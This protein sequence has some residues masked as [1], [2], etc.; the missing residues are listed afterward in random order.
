LA[1]QIQVPRINNNLPEFD[2]AENHIR[3]RIHQLM[4]INGK[5]SVDSIH[6]ELGHIMWEHV[7]MA[8]DKKGLMEAI[9]LLKDLKK[10]FWSNIR[11]PG[12]ADDLNVELEK[13]LR[14]ADFIEIGL[15]MAF[16]SLNREESCGGHFRTEHQTGEGEAL[17]HDD[18]FGYVA[19]WKYEGEDKDP[20]MLKEPLDYEFVERQQRN[21]K[22]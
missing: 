17:R 15:L 1:D 7:G 20:V 18:L 11:I 3:Q 6:K 9:E 2:E 22:N 5:R 4:S 13:A 16:D 8:R 12:K 19:C 14:L 10:Q 21:Y